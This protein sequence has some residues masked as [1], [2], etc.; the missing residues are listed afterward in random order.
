MRRV[1]SFLALFFFLAFCAHPARAEIVTFTTIN[2]RHDFQKY[3]HL[4]DDEM[5]RYTHFMRNEGNFRY[6]RLT[7]W[8][9]LAISAQ[10]DTTMRYYAKKAAI[11]EMRAVKAQLKY[12]LM[13]TEEK[14]R[15]WRR[16]Q[17]RQNATKPEA[18]SK[19]R[20]KPK[21]RDDRAT[22]SDDKI[23]AVKKIKPDQI[24]EAK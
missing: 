5:T 16:E 20:Q 3:W 19:K 24:K 11:A 9:V 22:Q 18:S 8:E 10:D 15:I 6:P 12:A 2:E 21:V 17:A 4:S 13:V 1:D 7:P 14:T 23:G